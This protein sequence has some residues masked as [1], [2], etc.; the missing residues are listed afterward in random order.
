MSDLASSFSQH[1]TAFEFAVQVESIDDI[2]RSQL[3]V[4]R[5]TETHPEGEKLL[6]ELRKRKLITAR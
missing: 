2:A 6:A 5:Q 3:E 1:E 4:I